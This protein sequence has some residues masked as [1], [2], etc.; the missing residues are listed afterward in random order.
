LL[1]SAL[2]TESLQ[3]KKHRAVT[4]AEVSGGSAVAMIRSGLGGAVLGYLMGVDNSRFVRTKARFVGCIFHNNTGYEGGALAMLGVDASVE[5]C[6]F[7][8][9]NAV[10]NGV[11]V[12]S[13]LGG[14]LNIIGS[15]IA[16]TSASVE[17]QRVNASQCLRGEY[18][19]P[20]GM[21]RRCAV[22]TYSLAVPTN[23]CLPCP[24][25]AQVCETAQ[26]TAQSDS[27]LTAQH[28]TASLKF[29]TQHSATQV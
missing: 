8:S 3:K 10:Q 17:W 22:S 28:S 2:V 27:R 7:A 5:N 16:L 6:T 1:G 29:D 11:D 18:F 25:N 9:N 4:F 21:C 26:R 23:T 24:S 15:N 19:G 14:S 13:S 20:T 12:F